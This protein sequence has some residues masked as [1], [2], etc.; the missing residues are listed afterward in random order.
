MI[1]EHLMVLGHGVLRELCEGREE[2]CQRRGG[3]VRHHLDQQA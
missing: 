3:Q 1:I 2:V